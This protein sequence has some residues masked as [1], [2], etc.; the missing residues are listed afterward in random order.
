MFNKQGIQKS[1]LH[2]FVI[3]TVNLYYQKELM[4]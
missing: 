3:Q 2:V 1:F 4:Y